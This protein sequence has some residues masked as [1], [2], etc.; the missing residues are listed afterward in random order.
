MFGNAV[1]SLYSV[2]IVRLHCCEL[3]YVRVNAIYNIGVVILPAQLRNP[4]PTVKLPKQTVTS[5]CPKAYPI[6]QSS[7]RITVQA[8]SV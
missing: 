4:P 3:H 7:P 6:D 2:I 5:S 8:D 1:N